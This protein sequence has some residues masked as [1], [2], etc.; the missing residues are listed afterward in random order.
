MRSGQL[1]IFD[2]LN[3]PNYILLSEVFAD[4]ESDE[5]EYKSALGGFPNEFW[6]TYSAFANSNGGIIVLGVKEKKNQFIVEG[7]TDELII[8]YQKE[9]WNNVNNRT[10]ASINLM[11]NSDVKAHLLEGKKVLSFRI[12]SATRTQKPVYLTANP[13]QNTYKRNYEGDYKCTD[14]EIRRMLSDA[15]LS[16]RPDS[17][18][19]EGYSL[20]DFDTFSLRQYRQIFASVRPTHNWLA[21]T[22]KELLI[23][24]G[25]YRID[26]KTRKEGPTLAGILMFGKSIS[27]TDDECCPKFFPDYE[28]FYQQ[29]QM[30]VGRI[31]YFLTVHG[32][33]IYFSFI[34]W[35]GPNYLLGYLSPFT[36]QRG[37]VKMKLQLMFLCVKHL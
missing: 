31:G 26:R 11:T 5:I 3:Q 19:L 12:P 35:Y 37:N 21:L 15:D 14:E 18:I 34:V 20:D 33:R 28:R 25:G 1:S 10:C 32:R 6:K 13:F 24:L 22:D 27:I 16:F 8:K 7:L 9:F 30:T 17:R 29:T 36:Y 2:V 23:Q 4:T